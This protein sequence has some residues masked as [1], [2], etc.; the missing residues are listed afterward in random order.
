MKKILHL[1]LPLFCFSLTHAQLLTWTPSF[2]VEN[3]AATNVV[4]TMDA[5]KGNQG[6][7]N[8]TSTSDVYVHIGVITNKSTSSTDWRHSLFTWGTTTAAAHCTSLGNNKWQYTI[9]GGIRSFFG[10][11]DATEHVLK[12]AILFRNGDGSKAQRNA[13]NSDMYVPV[14]DNSVI[15]VRFTDP[16]FQPLYTPQPEPIT[17]AIGDNI[18]VTAIANKT[19]TMK[20]YLNG[21]VIQ[22]ASSVT[23]ISA[24]PT[25]ITG[26]NNVIIRFRNDDVISSRD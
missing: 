9:T 2:P 26:G 8:Y 5:T 23:T 14:Y 20:L 16:L 21:T 10:I 18:S 4:I 13:D 17:K 15:A 12:I 1:V 25:L 24:N 19:S 22:T 11:T 7:L 3:D 6:L